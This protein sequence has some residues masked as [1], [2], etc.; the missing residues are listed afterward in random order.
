MKILIVGAGAVASVISKC[1]SKDKD[2]SE[3]V[4]ASKNKKNDKKFIDL[5]NSKISLTSADASDVK[6]IV[7]ISK[8]F[9]LIIN[10]SLPKFNE[11]IMKAALRVG[12]NYQDLCSWLAD[13]KTAEQL[14][15]HK[16]FHKEKLIGL[17]NTGISPGITN[18]L[19]R[20]VADKLDSVLEIRICL[21]E[22][23]KADKLIFAWSPEITLD[24]ITSPPLMYK[25][26]KFVLST[27]FDD[28]QEYDFPPPIGK[29]RVY[30]V[31]GDEVSTIPLYIKTKNVI[32]KCG[33]G[34]IEISKTLYDLGLFGKKPV[35][36]NGKKIA[37][38]QL[39]SKIAPRV[40]TPQ[41]MI[42]LV[43]NGSIENAVFVES[44]EAT[45]KRSGKK[46]KIRN[47]AIFPDFRK[48]YKIFP[49]A[50]YISYST[51][52]AAIAFSKVIT[53]IDSCGVFPPE[54]LSSKIR[55]EILKHLK[56]NG[57][58]IKEQFSV[59]RGSSFK[60]IN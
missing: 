20:E 34:D 50:T 26:G 23:Q 54:A 56:N 32:F 51:G 44:V 39:F 47:T 5:N 28:P 43:K 60:R 42:E 55:K 21:L 12:A 18:L 3:I 35:L 41:E 22:E 49:G 33:G 14:K 24:E 30:D 37:P 52:I 38:L 29:R 53:K 40:A 9:D 2:I 27:P 48:I 45:G 36:I 25:N 16:A 10:A 4:C 46:L 13:F 31:Y 59:D 57:V 8:D 6:Q 1:L 58:V 19:A 15:F 17:I 7:K 11:N